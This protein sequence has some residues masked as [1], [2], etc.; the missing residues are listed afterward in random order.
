MESPSANVLIRDCPFGTML[1]YTTADEGTFSPNHHHKDTIDTYL[2]SALQVSAGS[3]GGTKMAIKRRG[4][5]IH[6]RVPESQSHLP[7]ISHGS[8]PQGVQIT[9][10]QAPIT[11]RRDYNQNQ[12]VKRKEIR[13]PYVSHIGGI[14]RVS[15]VATPYVLHNHIANPDPNQI[16]RENSKLSGNVLELRHDSE[17]LRHEPTFSSLQKFPTNNSPFLDKRPKGRHGRNKNGIDENDFDRN[18]PNLQ[19][20]SNQMGLYQRAERRQKERSKGNSGGESFSIR[21]KIEQFRKWHEEQYREK[22]KK[23]KQEV[24]HQYDIEQHKVARQVAGLRET[25]TSKN[26]HS[27]NI[28]HEHINVDRLSSPKSQEK[29]D[30]DREPINTMSASSD[31]KPR[32]ESARTWRTWRQVNDSYAYNDVKKYIKDNELMDPEKE[33]WIKKW[34]IEVN[35]AMRD[36]KLKED[37]L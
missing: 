11:D 36:A 21:K 4:K 30:E 1:K 24:D 17:L 12:P 8:S 28:E 26:D 25:P 22:I 20:Q 19:I 23:L 27:V 10:A 16:M 2:T 7:P 34:I 5:R 6:A 15:D 3:K 14:N 35:S 29:M 33:L 18:A 9:S 13:T 32:T 37:L 31:V